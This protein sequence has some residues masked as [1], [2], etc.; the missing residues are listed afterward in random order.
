MKK[1]SSNPKRYVKVY[2]V[3]GH[4]ETPD[5]KFSVK[6]FSTYANSYQDHYKDLL[7]ELKPMRERVRTN[8]LS[9]LSALLQRDLDDLRV[10][11]GLIPYL[12][13]K[14]RG[15]EHNPNHIAFFPAI[16]VALI[17][18][19]YIS[20][21]GPS[22]YPKLHEGLEDD[23]QISFTY[24]TEER[25]DCWRLE[26]FK[27]ENGDVTPL[28]S[29]SI[30]FSIT[31]AIVLDGQ[32]RANAFRVLTGSFWEN[33]E[34]QIYGP[35]YKE[36]EADETYKS[37]LPLTIIWFESDSEQVVDPRYISRELFVAVNNNARLISK[38]RL[39]LLNDKDPS[40]L[41][42]RFWYSKVAE[43]H[44]F[45][46][47]TPSLNMLHMG[48]DVN[49]DL[50]NSRSHIF[51]LT[52]PEIIYDVVDWLYFGPVRYTN[53]LD[54]YKVARQ[55]DRFDTSVFKYYFPNSGKYVRAPESDYEG[56]ETK[57]VSDIEG[58]E[59][60]KEEFERLCYPDLKRL[61]E[62]L[63]FLQPHYAATH[64]IGKQRKYDW[65]SVGLK[66]V[67]DQLYIG[68]EGLYY[69]IKH[70]D[71]SDPRIKDVLDNIKTIESEFS[72]IRASFFCKPPN[73]VDEAYRSFTTKAFQ[74]A[75]FK[76]YGDFVRRVVNLYNDPLEEFLTR[77]NAVTL[78]QW[79][80][81][82]IDFRKELISTVDPK[83][84]PAYHKILLRF[85]QKEGE[86]FHNELNASPEAE[87]F[88]KYFLN[89]C[90]KFADD[91]GRILSDMTKEELSA[92]ILNQW[93]EDI[94][95]RVIKFMKEGGLETLDL[96]FYGNALQILKDKVNAWS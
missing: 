71:P 79:L 44:S 52:E 67:W 56:E 15:N 42:T 4:F 25:H 2:G 26:Q 37:D 65:D 17:P 47:D 7:S 66:E 14:I 41:I 36:V 21:T 23:A 95:G 33:K 78:D 6:Y 87:L 89:R 57:L 22:D 59:V 54:K 64:S 96:D 70:L 34:N 93:V 8:E 76:T 18:K 31:D 39:V 75:Y 40:A 80:F 30:D 10:S 94:K 13:N 32:H 53:E 45:S 86:F 91:S 84:W 90:Y 72:A 49:R 63:S 58:V 73:I 69:G 1:I 51:T 19:G 85:I 77:L 3:L 27:D 48:F 5:S 61:F 24:E 81:I 20:R 28:A 60:L 43:E 35:F 46:C 50:R 62:E 16:L 9:D 74:V 83:T 88:K 82:L 92:D 11:N 55:R 68:G 29:L 12:V 38:S